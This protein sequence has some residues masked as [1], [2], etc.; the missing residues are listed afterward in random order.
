MKEVM[1]KHVRKGEWFTRKPIEYPNE[2]QVYIRGD[3]DRESK[4]YECTHWDDCLSNGVMLKGTTIVYV[5][6]TF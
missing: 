5:D 3:Y 6:F 1:L 2:H 4:K